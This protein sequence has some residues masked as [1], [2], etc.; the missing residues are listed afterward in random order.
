MV[1]S[2]YLKSLQIFW[3]QANDKMNTGI[4]IISHKRPQCVTWH[5]L[6]KLGYAG[7]LKIIADDLDETDYEAIYGSDVVRFNK[8]KYAEKADTMD[9]FGVLATP[10]YARNA[11]LDIG[12]DE[13]YD[14]VGVFD[15][16]LTGFAYRYIDGRKL[17]SKKI[18]DFSK[19]FDLYCEFILNAGFDCAGFVSDRKLIG[20]IQNKIVSNRFYPMITGMYIFNLHKKQIP[21]R[22]TLNED[23]IFVFMS[24]LLGRKVYSFL[25]IVLKTD[26]VR[27]MKTGGCKELYTRYSNWVGENYIHMAIP[28]LNWHLEGNNLR[29]GLSL[30]LPRF[31]N[32]EWKK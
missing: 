30:D 29:Y 8:N 31:L 9:N 25:P 32:E 7:E 27:A 1:M 17:R 18:R 15:D 28:L 13:G 20:G 16:D 6:K 3:I 22:G 12:K 23:V 24:N 21:F 11:C 10:L 14:C 5:T 2:N 4:F 19:V 26:T